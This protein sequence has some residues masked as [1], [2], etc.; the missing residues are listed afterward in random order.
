MQAEHMPHVISH[1]QGNFF[2]GFK[3]KIS[4]LQYQL[5]FRAVDLLDPMRDIGLQ[6]YQRINM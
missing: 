4:Q 5:I 1:L 3:A 6:V 2:P